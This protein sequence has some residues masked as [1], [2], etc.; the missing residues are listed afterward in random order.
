[1]SNYSL[2]STKVASKLGIDLNRLGR[3]SLTTVARVRLWVLPQFTLSAES[4]RL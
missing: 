2:D 4:P 1:M 3:R